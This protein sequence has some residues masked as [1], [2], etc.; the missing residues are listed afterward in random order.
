[1]RRLLMFIT[2]ALLLTS[3]WLAFTVGEVVPSEDEKGVTVEKNILYVHVP[4]AICSTLCFLVLLLTSIAY[5]VN[6]KPIFDYI[7][8][9]SA[10]AALVFTTVLN[11]T[12]CIFSRVFW[13][14]WWTPTPRLLTS[15]ILWFLAVAYLIL[16]AGIQNQRHRA[17]LCAVFGI[18]AFIDVP[19]VFISARMMRDMHPANVGFDTAW[20]G[21]SFGLSVLSILSLAALFI[22]LRTDILRSRAQL[23][24]EMYS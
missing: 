6:S 4:S 8:A 17:R 7:G 9:A 15:A 1:M 20:Q 2:L 13:G 10:E 5:L 12:G 3:T 24:N 23:E 19:M 16:R 22:W 11:L 18:I 21:V 14:P